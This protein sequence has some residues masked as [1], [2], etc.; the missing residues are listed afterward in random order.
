M[1]KNTICFACR[2]KAL[3]CHDDYFI[4]IVIVKTYYLAVISMKNN[5]SIT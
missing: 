3:T 4:T 5:Y 2:L 1:I